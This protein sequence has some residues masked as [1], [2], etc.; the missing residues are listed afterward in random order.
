MPITSTPASQ[1]SSEALL[2]AADLLSEW[3]Q[4][5]PAGAVPLTLELR[6]AFNQFVAE[7]LSTTQETNLEIA[8]VQEV[9]RKAAGLTIGCGEASGPGRAQQ[10]L[11]AAYQTIQSVGPGTASQGQI[12]LLLQSR[13][14]TELE[15]DELTDI[16]ETMW[17]NAGRE[18]EIVFGHGVAPG[19]PAEIRVRFLLAPSSAQ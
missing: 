19:L 7:V 4:L 10:A 9:L 1:S 16:T 17:R 12:L 3:E 13:P 2:R 15:M 6:T 11:Q 14:D 18:W 8:D 5:R